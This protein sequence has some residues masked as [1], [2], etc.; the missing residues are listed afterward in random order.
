MSTDL[1]GYMLHSE[2]NGTVKRLEKMSDED[3]IRERNIEITKYSMSKEL[4]KDPD[5]KELD[6]TEGLLK[7]INYDEK[8]DTLKSVRKEKLRD[9]LI[10]RKRGSLT[11]EKLKEYLIEKKDNKDKGKK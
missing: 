10:D 3:L 11:K 8:I 5:T 1:P 9:Y 2:K 6:T 4:Q 7:N